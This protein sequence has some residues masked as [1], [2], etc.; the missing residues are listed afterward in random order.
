MKKIW[1]RI[2]ALALTGLMGV[3]A[4]GCG[5][6]GDTGD[7]T[8]SS[9]DQHL[10]VY[11]I[12][13]GYRTDGAKAIV[14]TFAQLDWVKTKYPNLQI[15]YD[16]NNM[17]G[18]ALTKVKSPKTNDYDIMFVLDDMISV[19]EKNSKGENLLLNLTDWVYNTE[20]LDKAGVTYKDTIHDSFLQY[21][22]Y[23]TK[24]ETEP[25]YY[26][27]PWVTGYMGILYSEEILAKYGYT[28]GKTPNTT[29]EFLALCEAIKQNPADSGNADG[30]SFINASGYYS[31]MLDTW[32]AQY[33]GLE[34]YT[35]FWQGKYTD[36]RGTSYSNKIFELEGR[37]K[38]LEVIAET[39]YYENGYYDLENQD[40]NDFMVRQAELLKGH[41]AFCVC[42]DWYDTEMKATKDELEANGWDTHTV[43]IMKMP[44]VSALGD[45]L[46]IDD[47]TLSKV[48]EAIDSG[49]TS[50]DGVSDT[51]FKRVQE[52]RGIYDQAGMEHEVVIPAV[53]DDQDIAVDILKFMATKQAQE[54]YMAAT[55]GQNMPFE[56]DYNYETLPATVKDAI[57]PLQKSR[58]DYYYNKSFP[59]HV[60]PSDRR[61]PLVRS[62]SFAPLE[63]QTTNYNT[64]FALENN[65]TTPQDIFD[66]TKNHWTQQVFD[67]A[68]FSAGLS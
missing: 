54:A 16:E 9:G 26:G 50:C 14:N 32:W 29:D 31:R 44:I 13:H 27:V 3:A 62:A 6:N 18:Y 53:A 12:N 19:Y 40:A 22:A 36:A 39:S 2:S 11:I 61:Y 8:L 25:Q 28:D 49:A 59:I 37:L 55:M 10:Q 46:G 5:D 23:T 60:L 63:V 57:S 34:A 68:L 64:I 45:K 1:K 43:K 51:V 48:V 30:F 67:F 42:A 17:S 41:Y 21:L 52:A 20:V 33:D 24:T 65:T 66:D 56:Y 38:S 47:A 35:N 15:T 7:G 58:L 4:V